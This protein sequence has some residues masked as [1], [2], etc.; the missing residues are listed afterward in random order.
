MREEREMTR[1]A[2]A[3]RSGLTTGSVARVELAQSVPGWDTVRLL[4]K[5]LGVTLAQLAAEVEAE[6]QQAP[7]AIASDQASS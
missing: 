1:E 4:A 6:S 2:L 3:F 5:A 7:G